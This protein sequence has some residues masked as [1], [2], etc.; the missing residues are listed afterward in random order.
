MEYFFHIFIIYLFNIAVAKWLPELNFQPDFHQFHIYQLDPNQNRIFNTTDRRLPKNFEWLTVGSVSLSALNSSFIIY[1]GN[2][3]SSKSN[4]AF[5]IRMSAVV[6]CQLKQSKDT[7]ILDDIRCRNQEAN[8]PQYLGAAIKTLSLSDK[9]AVLVY[10]DPLW[11]KSNDKLSEPSGKC[12][13]T[14][15]NDKKNRRIVEIKFCQKGKDGYGTCMG[16]FSVDL[17]RDD[18]KVSDIKMIVGMPHFSPYGKVEMI[19]DPFGAQKIGSL[20]NYL[21]KYNNFGYAVAMTPK[22]YTYVSSPMSDQYFPNVTKINDGST[23]TSPDNDPF[24]SFGVALTTLSIKGDKI[25][26]VI[27]APF[28]SVKSVPNVGK[29]YIFCSTLTNQSF[30]AASIFGVKEDEFL[31][32][33]LAN[34]GDINGDGNEDLAIGSPFLRNDNA[35][36]HVAI[37]TV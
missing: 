31:G 19:K 32:Y 28:H 15:L 24:S 37:Y 1:G 5:N 36:G 13:L 7:L 23:L 16:G 14:L 21:G 3:Q 26:I 4:T 33:S 27:G 2:Q 11:H 17:I 34:I 9:E 18:N 30:L 10:C 6:L 8:E 12:Y 22:E 29:V 25:A 35:S 20:R